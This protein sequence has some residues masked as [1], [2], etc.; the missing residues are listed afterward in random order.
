MTVTPYS[1]VN[2][3]ETALTVTAAVQITKTG[4]DL[5]FTITGTGLTPGSH[6]TLELTM[7]VTSS[8][9]ANTGQVNSVSYVA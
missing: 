1:E 8:S 5:A 2:G 3:V 4:G 7:L 9:G 6:I